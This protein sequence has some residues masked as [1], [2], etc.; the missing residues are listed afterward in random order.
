MVI[1]HVVLKS[2][3]GKTPTQAV[4]KAVRKTGCHQMNFCLHFLE[5]VSELTL[6][7]KNWMKICFVMK[8]LSIC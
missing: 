3:T 8:S 2:G 7:L 5:K 6:F 1:V 4:R